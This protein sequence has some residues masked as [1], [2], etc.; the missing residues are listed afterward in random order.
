MCDP[1]ELLPSSPLAFQWYGREVAPEHASQ[2]RQG[3]H[4][5]ELT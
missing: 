2:L 1:H 3:A 5:P 4:L